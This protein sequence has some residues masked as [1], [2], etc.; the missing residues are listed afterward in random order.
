VSSL[1]HRGYV[2]LGMDVSK[3]SIAAAVLSPDSDV[4]E[5]DK[6]SSDATLSANSSS[7][8]A[9]RRN[10]GLLRSGPTGYELQRLL[11]SMACAVK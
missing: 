3:D 2:H 5:L 9:G 6:I 4:A 1:A 8:S 10:L 11:T 7:A